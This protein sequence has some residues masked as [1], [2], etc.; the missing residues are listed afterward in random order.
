[1]RPTKLSIPMP[2]LYRRFELKHPKLQPWS[3]LYGLEPVGVGGQFVESLTGYFARV[4][5][6]HS[7][8]VSLLFG[9][10][11]APLL[12]K[13]YLRRAVAR[14]K[15]ACRLFASAFRPLARAINGLGKGA[16]EWVRVLERLTLRSDLRFLTL[17]PL[18][19]V[20]AR[21]QLLRPSRAWCPLC[22]EEWLKKGEVIYEPLL[23]AVKAVTACQRHQLPLQTICGHCGKSLHPLSSRSR[24][25]YCSW[26]EEWLGTAEGMTMTGATIQS[27]ESQ[28][29]WA[30]SAVGE[31]LAAASQLESPPERSQILETLRKCLDSQTGGLPSRL[32]MEKGQNYAPAGYAGA[33]MSPRRSVTCEPNDRKG[34]ACQESCRVTL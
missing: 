7:L 21:D 23:W 28:E 3:R 26:C 32:A 6:A 17:L 2:V 4:A 11:V 1:M 30:A 8:S 14:S 9:Y 20:V 18:G 5:Q 34:K 13:E 31:A 27:A 25:G 15:Y 12:D 24:P 10:E 16:F 33:S 19:A 29:L 22:Y